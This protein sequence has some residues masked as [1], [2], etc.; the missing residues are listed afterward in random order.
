MLLTT[1]KRAEEL[2]LPI[3]GRF[4]SFAVTGVPPEI[5]GIGPVT[6]VRPLSLFLFLRAPLKRNRHPQLR[7]V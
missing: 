2:K 3:I 4:R 7:S 6:A 5:M 1:R